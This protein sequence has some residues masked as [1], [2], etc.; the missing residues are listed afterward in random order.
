MSGSKEGTVGQVTTRTITILPLV[1]VCGAALA[2]DRSDLCNSGNRGGDLTIIRIPD[3]VKWGTVGNITA[4]SFGTDILN[5]GTATLPI[6]AQ[7]DAHPVMAQNLYRME[8]GRFEQIGLSW[9]KHTFRATPNDPD[10]TC[11]DPQDDQIIGVGCTD[12][13][14]ALTNGSQAGFQG[15]AIG[16][17]GP[18]SDLN[19]STAEFPWPFTTRGD[20]GDAIYKRLQAENAD[21]DPDR[22]PTARLFVESMYVAPE[23]PAENRYNNVSYREVSV[24][25]F[26]DGGWVLR[27]ID[28]TRV[29][30]PALSAWQ[31]SDRNVDIQTFDIPDDGIIMLGALSSQQDDG[32]WHYEYV[33]FNMNSDRGVDSFAVSV[34]PGTSISDVEFSGVKYHSGER[35]NS[36]DWSAVTSDDAVEWRTTSEAVE[37]NNNVLRWG[38]AYR[39]GF[40]ADAAPATS[41]GTIHLAK[42][43]AD[44][45]I[46]LL[47]C[48]PGSGQEADEGCFSPVIDEDSD[49]IDDD[50]DLCL[51]T[52]A[53]ETVDAQ[54]CSE[55]QLADLDPPGSDPVSTCGASG[56]MTLA[57]TILGF[58]AV[59]RTR[60]Y[61][62]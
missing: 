23:E 26:T 21:V 32:R 48:A 42:D 13:Y 15:S 36:T 8:N 50:V 38:T 55:A 43:G 28:E 1:I 7:S 2:G 3:Q 4:Y 60:R 58:I 6:S 19:P 49:G 11:D 29:G 54:G 33:L 52:A 10:C 39:F 45:N 27:V 9:L 57:L 18:R 30:V 62:A 51:D 59:A 16:G 20:T 37:A 31:E 35:W 17:I 61:A 46:D 14:T 34:A 44:P 24:V 40:T 56:A 47:V 41:A 25:D 12:P 22:H 5:V 53:T